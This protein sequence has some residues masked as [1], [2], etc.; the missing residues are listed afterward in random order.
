LSLSFEVETPFWHTL[1]F[2]GLLMAC[3]FGLIWMLFSIRIRTIRR[4]QE[5]KEQ[6]SR[7]M[8]ELEHKALQAQ[9][10]PHFIFNCL[11]S[12]Q[13]YVFAQDI[14]AANK[15]I[16]G[17]AKLIRATLNNSTRTF[18]FLSEETDYLNSYLSLEKLRFKDMMDYFIDVDPGINRHDLL[19]PPMLIQ[20][21]VENSMRHGLR[22][23]TDGK[24]YI[25]IKMMQMD[26]QLVVIVEDN[27]I[28]RERAAQYKTGEH[29]EYQS[30]GMIL[31]ADRIRMMNAGNEERI[32]VEVTDLKDAQ[33]RAT[34]TRV[35]ISF[36]LF[37][38]TSQKDNL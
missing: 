15:Y 28:G 4:R 13:Q 2:Y 25:R 7:R 20:P 17:F 21:Y 11:N 35:T 32:T 8:T 29:I 37:H 34:G 6:V 33:D 24:G 10:N 27:G 3:F 30:K 38:I 5:E 31:T 19:I 18:I 26:N 22:H 9:M 14:F 12:I 23:K 1:W 36:P 16:T